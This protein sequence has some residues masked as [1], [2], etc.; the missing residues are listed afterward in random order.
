MEQISESNKKLRLCIKWF[1]GIEQ[2]LIQEQEALRNSLDSSEKK[3]AEMDA[4]K[5]SKEDELNAS[6]ES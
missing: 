4:Q 6:L 5:K 1:Q 3:C 2:T